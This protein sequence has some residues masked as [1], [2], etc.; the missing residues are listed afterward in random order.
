MCFFAIYIYS[1]ITILGDTFSYLSG[2]VQEF[3]D[4][5]LLSSTGFM[6][7]LGHFFKAIFINDAIACFPFLYLAYWG[8]KYP[9]QKHGKNLIGPFFIVLLLLPNFNI[10]TSII[11]KEAVGCFFSGILASWVINYIEKD[12]KIKLI[13]LI[14][15]GL[16]I[17][18]KPQYFIFVFEALLFLYLSSKLKRK[19]S[20]ALLA[21][22]IWTVNISAIYLN[23]DTI[24]KFASLLD[25][26][27]YLDS[28]GSTRE[29]SYFQETNG[30][31]HHLPDGMFTAFF[32]PTMSEML[33][34]PA[35]FFAGLESIL[36]VGIFSLL[37]FLSVVKHKIT[38]RIFWA[39]SFIFIGILA[40]HYPFGIFNPGSAIRYR[41]N[42]YLLFVILLVYM[43]K[44]N[45]TELLN[46][47][48]NQS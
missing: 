31:I 6:M 38:S 20:I 44:Q 17:Q 1:K 26:N 27:F 39:Y 22:F 21:I 25:L 23:L 5:D 28:A 7:K 15:S 47:T 29:I 43:Y 37:V 36:I 45:N 4:L 13:F 18:F 12:F 16:C 48:I 14:A 10:Y 42:F 32:G 34:K 8:I 2:T 30:I 46:K 11:S 40:V 19:F 9:V 41:E 24:N 33:Q 35:H 3:Q